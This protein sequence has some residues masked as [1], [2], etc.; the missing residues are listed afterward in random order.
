MSDREDSTHSGSE[1]IM[2][3]P[4]GAIESIEVPISSQPVMT[5][6][7]P[8]RNMYMAGEHS[9]RDAP[10]PCYKKSRWDNHL[11]IQ[12]VELH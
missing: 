1:T 5:Q 6:D 12:V 11:M 2:S 9:G 10:F 8:K 7:I 3:F 4:A